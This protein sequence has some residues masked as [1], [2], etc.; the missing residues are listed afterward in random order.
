MIKNK[1]FIATILVSSFFLNLNAEILE[2]NQ[3]FNKKLVKVKEENFAH[4]KSFYGKV[5]FD[6][7]KTVDIITRYDGYITKLNA[8]KNFMYVKKGETL[9]SI[10][11]DKVLSIQRELQISKSINK[12]LY[13]S[14]YEKLIAL[15]INK[16]E[17][18]KILKSK[19]SLKNIKVTSPSNAIVIKKN[20]NKGSFVKKGK[21][22]LQLAN[23]DTLWF[24]AQVY[25]KDL[26]FIKKDMSA[27]IYIDGVQNNIIS[28]VEYIYPIVNEKTKTV[29]VRFSIENKDL[30]LYPNMFAKV[31]IKNTTNKII[32]L[33]KT[34]VLIKGDKAYV[35][36][37][38]SKDEIEPILIEARRVSSTKYEI[39]DGLNI[40]DEVINNALFLL[41][42]DAV[43]NN[44]YDDEDTD[45]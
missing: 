30:K 17:L 35:F 42:S 3:L 21:L 12:S 18:N 41:D 36:K 24:I 16:N 33:P 5:T 8:N 9:F 19:K 43:T 15:D 4:T 11:S 32:T 23:I 38:I 2:V 28:K 37:P 14:V 29:D 31:V 1:I 44:L 27:K 40:G 6:E 22:L 25:Q 7:S 10:Y 39:L 45:W 20:I 13:N 34:A 26:A